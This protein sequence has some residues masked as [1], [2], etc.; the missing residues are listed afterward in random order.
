MGE[1]G[2]REFI[3]WFYGQIRKEGLV[4]DVRGNGGGNVSQMIIERLSRKLLGSDFSRTDDL[5]G[6]YPSTVFLGP[7]VC[8]L[9]ETSGSDGDIFPHM[10][11]QA[12]LGPLIGKR[13]WGGVVGISGRGP[14]LDGGEVYVPESG[15]AGP[16]GQWII[17]GHGVDPDIEVDNRPEAVLAGGDPQLERA[18]EEIVKLLPTRPTKLPPPPADPVKTKGR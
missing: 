11:R 9:S 1:D 13:S 14:L 8:L 12:G 17:E 18:I 5:A 2:I 4:V 3:K 6:T 16:D 10:F 15:T 7:M